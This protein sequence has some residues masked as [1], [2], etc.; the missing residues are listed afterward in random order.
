M[1]GT[2]MH[3]ILVISYRYAISN[4]TKKYGGTFRHGT[5]RLCILLFCLQTVKINLKAFSLEETVFFFTTNKVEG[6]N[7]LL[8]FEIIAQMIKK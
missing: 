5:V 4:G 7:I 8:V 6:I 1:R 2:L 3:D